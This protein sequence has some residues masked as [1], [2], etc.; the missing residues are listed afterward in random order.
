MDDTLL[1]GLSSDKESKY[2]KQILKDFMNASGMSI[3]KNNSHIFLTPP[4]IQRSITR[5]LDFQGS[6]L[7]SK[8]LGAPL[9]KSTIKHSI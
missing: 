5:I 7:L 9:I 8:Y 4:L 2:F 3:K 1:M 6:S